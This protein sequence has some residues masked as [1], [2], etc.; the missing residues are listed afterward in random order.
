M[1]LKIL[2]KL[3][4]DYWIITGDLMLFVEGL[5]PDLSELFLTSGIWRE[6]GQK[7]LKPEQ[8][9]KVDIIDH[10]HH[11]YHYGNDDHGCDGL[12]PMKRTAHSRSNCVS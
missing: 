10:L 6:Y 5:K 8:I 1:A 2:R 4:A 9:D 11:E 7:C 3:E 12:K